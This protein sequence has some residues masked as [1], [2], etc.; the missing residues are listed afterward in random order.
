[1]FIRIK[2]P[3]REAI[4]QVFELERIGTKVIFKGVSH[5]AFIKCKDEDEA[6]FFFEKLKQ[7]LNE[8][9]TFSKVND[10]PIIADLNSDGAKDFRP[11]RGEK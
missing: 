11:V 3:N 6:E 8:T 4:F 5:N 1:M 2:L 9:G 10:Y 7:N